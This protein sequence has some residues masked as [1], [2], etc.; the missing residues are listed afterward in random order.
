VGGIPVHG[1][2]HGSVLRKRIGGCYSYCARG[3][4]NILQRSFPGV[5]LM[6]LFGNFRV[7]QDLL[8]PGAPCGRFF[9]AQTEPHG[10]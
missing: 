5:M 8:K 4:G 7:P 2:G 3:E 10:R 9:L 1:F 6:H